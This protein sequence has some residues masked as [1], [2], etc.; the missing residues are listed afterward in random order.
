MNRRWSLV[1]LTLCA[2]LFALCSSA[3]AQGKTF[4]VGYLDPSSPSVTEHLLKA[5]RD[6][7]NKRGWIEGKNVTIEYRFA[8]LKSER[9]FEQARDLVRWKADVILAAGGAPAAARKV[10]STIP[11]VV[12]TGIIWCRPASRKVSRSP[13]G[14]SRDSP[15]SDRS[16]SPSDWRS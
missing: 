8:E 14:T 15:S 2:L 6:E 10:T 13:E 3:Q 1:G 5:F 7:M 9:Q 4:R 16:L 12:A 11:I